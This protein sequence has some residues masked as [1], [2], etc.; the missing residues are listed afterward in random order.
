MANLFSVNIFGFTIVL[1]IL[2]LFNGMLCA[3]NQARY[4]NYR[5]YRLTLKTNE[6]VR[7]FADLEERSD[8]YTFYGHARQIDQSLTIM[9]A[10]HK[11]AEITELLKRYSVPHAVLVIYLF[12]EIATLL[13]INLYLINI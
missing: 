13:L 7:L 10:S 2:S 9:V 11:I 6:H 1:C 12:D 3:N 8:S 5:L 4:D